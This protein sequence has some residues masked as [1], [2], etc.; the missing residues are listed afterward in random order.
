MRLS[1]LAWVGFAFYFHSLS[2]TQ[3]P[4]FV[5]YSRGNLPLVLVLWANGSVYFSIMKLALFAS[6]F[7]RK[8][9]AYWLLQV[10]GS[11]SFSR[12]VFI[13]YWFSWLVFSVR[14][15]MSYSAAIAASSEPFLLTGLNSLSIRTIEIDEERLFST[16]LPFWVSKFFLSVL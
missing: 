11:D 6:C 2:L 7:M 14:S 5:L 16:L 12:D 8:F 10:P 13:S 1:F 9:R 4:A 3:T 15:R